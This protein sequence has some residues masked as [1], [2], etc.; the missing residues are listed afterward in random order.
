MKL[1]GDRAV[2]C[3]V[4]GAKDEAFVMRICSERYVSG[5]SSFSVL[6]LTTDIEFVVCV[7]SVS[8]VTITSKSTSLRLS[9]PTV[10]GIID[11]YRFCSLVF[12]R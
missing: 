9:M 10:I 5:I 2:G 8:Y 11:F 1:C 12:R 6:D 7:V 3:T 4:R